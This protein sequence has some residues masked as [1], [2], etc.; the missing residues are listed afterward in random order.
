MNYLS[1]HTTYEI[2]YAAADVAAR[3]MLQ[4]VSHQQRVFEPQEEQAMAGEAQ[5]EQKEQASAAMDIIKHELEDSPPPLSPVV[6]P[7]SPATPR[8]CAHPAKPGVEVLEI[9]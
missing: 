2:V 6:R 9:E 1:Q 3:L 7:A 8:A 5:E 4:T